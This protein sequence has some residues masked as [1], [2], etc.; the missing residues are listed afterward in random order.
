MKKLLM[1]ICLLAFS[2]TT[3]VASAGEEAAA[4]KDPASYLEMYKEFSGKCQGLRRGDVRMLRSTHPDKTIEYR[5]VRLLAG[6][7]QASIIRGEIEPQSEGQKLGCET[8]G[9]RE[10]IW[11]VTSARFVE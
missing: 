10:Q 1:N 8:L 9:E 5:L 3:V 7:R 11:E 4:D 2:T 6:K